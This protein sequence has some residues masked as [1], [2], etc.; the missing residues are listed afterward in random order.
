LPI[1]AN[2]PVP[3]LTVLVIVLVL[4]IDPHSRG[5]NNQMAGT[6]VQ[7]FPLFQTAWPSA[8][9]DRARARF[10]HNEKARLKKTRNK[11]V[12]NTWISPKILFSF[13]CESMK[14]TLWKQ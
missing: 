10:T 1:P 4:V 11:R 2:D 7:S 3:S 9:K 5:K 14:P 13:A 8:V 6:F 12:A